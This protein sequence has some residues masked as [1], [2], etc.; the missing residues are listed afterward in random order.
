[1]SLAAVQMKEG[2]V[3]A[4]VYG[5]VR[6]CYDY[7][8]SQQFQLRLSLDVVVDELDVVFIKLTVIL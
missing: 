1:M 6:L 2:E 4:T 3:T 7:V 5:L 8:S